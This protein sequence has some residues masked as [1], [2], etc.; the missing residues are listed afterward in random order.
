MNFLCCF[1]ISPPK[2]EKEN[3]VEKKEEFPS[4]VV[5]ESLCDIS[6]SE[7]Q[8]ES[9]SELQINSQP[10][11]RRNLKNSLDSEIESFQILV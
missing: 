5:M 7:R 3:L 1:P 2:I 9:R 11:N 8:N 4:V 6:R 10:R